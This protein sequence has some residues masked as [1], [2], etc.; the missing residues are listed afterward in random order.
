[1]SDTYFLD[2]IGTAPLWTLGKEILSGVASQIIFVPNAHN[3][4]ISMV[5]KTKYASGLDSLVRQQVTWWIM[6]TIY[7]AGLVRS[8][9]GHKSI[10]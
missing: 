6:Y 1:M 3:G 8:D 2:T 10:G 7:T 5:P 4:T 9:R